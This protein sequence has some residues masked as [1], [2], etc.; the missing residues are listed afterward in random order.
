MRNIFLVFFV[1][2]SFTKSFSQSGGKSTYQFLNLPFAARTAALGGNAISTKDDDINLSLQNP[3]LLDSSMHNKL[4]LNYIN[5]FTDVN[6]GY[7]AYARHFKN[8]GTFSGGVQFLNYGKFTAADETGLITGQFKA[9]DYSLNLSY[10][11]AIDSTF[12]IGG[13]LKTIYS[14]LEQY[15][16]VGSA[17]DIAATYYNKKRLFTAAAVIKN[18]GI[19]WK[20]YRP[21]NRE[22][23]PFEMQLGVSKKLQKAPLR[24]SLIGQHLEIWNMTYED[25]ANPTLTADPLTGETIKQNK[26]KIFG[27]KLMRHVTVGTEFL[28]TKNFNIR[29]GYNYLRRQELKVDTRPGMI[30]F[31][32]G[33]GFKISKFNLSYGRAAYHLAGASNHFSIT[34]N[35]SDFY[36]KK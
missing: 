23:L 10:A 21:G 36:S 8:I 13:T 28:L 32:F 34:T 30:G 3:S 6:Y 12:S 22:P 4:A 11:R 33:V 7:T 18:I 15:T 9:A 2:V 16:S 25:P 17:I 31:S 19:Q 29:L 24:F 14:V 1:F 27:D 35:L 26:A 5:Y 20:P